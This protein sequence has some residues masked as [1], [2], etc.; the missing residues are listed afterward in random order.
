MQAT[1]ALTKPGAQTHHDF[2]L[3]ACL[4]LWTWAVTT[5]TLAE[6]LADP[7]DINGPD[8]RR[9]LDTPR[10]DPR[11]A[12]R[13]VPIPCLPPLRAGTFASRAEDPEATKEGDLS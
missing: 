2:P 9:S 1:P 6:A 5:S 13:R 12:W 4:A 8:P 10:S 11:I 7:W 3:V